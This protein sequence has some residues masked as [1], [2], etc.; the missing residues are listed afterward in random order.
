MKEMKM[1]RTSMLSL[2]VLPA[3]V[4]A[5]ACAPRAAN[6]LPGAG[7]PNPASVYCEENGGHLE[8]R[9]DESGEVT[10]VCLFAGGE[11]CEEW[12]FLRGEC[13]PADTN[14]EPADVTEDGWHVYR[15]ARLGYSLHYPP[16][17]T[18]VENDEPLRSFSIVGPTGSWP[19]LTLSHP[20]EQADWQPPEG[21][22]LAQWLLDHNLM[23]AGAGPS[24]EVRQPDVQIGG[25]RAI[26]VRF[27]RS[28]QSY[29]YDRYYF[30]HDGQLYMLVIGH[31][32]DKEDW[33]MYERFLS[34]IK[35]DR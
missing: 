33:S 12:A 6:D 24:P 31:V 21:A 18:I 11:E 9:S 25:A 16:E 34:S 30:A 7:I 23:Q 14:P 35:F 27:E 15:N 26:H 10:G 20:T 17:S 5:S 3:V 28:P 2:M 13:A 22:D 4:L 29:A 8:L 1:A 19:S 32:D